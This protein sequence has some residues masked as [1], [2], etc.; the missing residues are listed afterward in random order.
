MKSF[1]Q[2]L[3]FEIYEFLRKQHK[4][5]LFKRNVK[6]G[7]LVIGKHSYG[8]PEVQVY[9]GSEAKVVIGKFCSIGPNC[10]FITGG[11]HPTNWV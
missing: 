1:F 5:Y 11:I 6:N 4:Y 7:F 9:K 10:L 2:K 3:F 8:M